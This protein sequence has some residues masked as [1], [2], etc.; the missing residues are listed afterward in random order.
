M[1][2]FLFILPPKERLEAVKIKLEE[3]KKRN[4]I[5]ASTQIIQ[6]ASLDIGQNFEKTQEVF[7]K[8]N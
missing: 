2:L 3:M 8:V 7:D 1:I 6:I 4:A 5:F